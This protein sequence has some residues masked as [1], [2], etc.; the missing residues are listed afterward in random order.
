MIDKNN[1]ELLDRAKN[2]PYQRPKGSFLL[3]ND[4]IVELKGR[5]LDGDLKKFVPVLAYGSNASGQNTGPYG[6]YQPRDYY[7]QGAPEKYTYDVTR[8]QKAGDAEYDKQ[9]AALKRLRTRDS[10]KN[11]PQFTGQGNLTTQNVYQQLGM[12]KSGGLKEDIQKIRNK[13]QQFSNGGRASVRGTKF[14]GVF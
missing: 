1:S 13:K 4:R 6:T 9:S 10:F 11:M 3:E 8:A 14:K 5:V 7:V 2:Y 12:A